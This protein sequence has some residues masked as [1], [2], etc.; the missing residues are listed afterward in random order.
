MN[1]RELFIQARGKWKDERV[2]CILYIPFLILKY[3]LD[4]F[5]V[6]DKL[7]DLCEIKVTKSLILSS[8]I[9]PKIFLL[10]ISFAKKTIFQL[11][12]HLDKLNFSHFLNPT[13]TLGLTLSEPLTNIVLK[14]ERFLF[15]I[16]PLKT[17]N[18]LCGQLLVVMT[19]YQTM[20]NKS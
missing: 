12:P 14:T 7:L 5:L 11:T 1:I 15:T 10:Q 6:F 17:G 2:L 16:F 4:V 19:Y 9:D 13:N 20:A 3:K 8:S 18:F